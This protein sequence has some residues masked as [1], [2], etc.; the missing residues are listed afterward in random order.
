MLLWEALKLMGEGVK[1]RSPHWSPGSWLMLKDGLFYDEN[2]P[3]IRDAYLTTKAKEV[4]QD[5]WEIFVDD[6][7]QLKRIR[8]MIRELGR[9]AER[10]GYGF[11][12]TEREDVALKWLDGYIEELSE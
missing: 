12:H 7:E 9:L 1:I 5:D 3:R 11:I 4:L 10:N 2:G 8:T 6:I